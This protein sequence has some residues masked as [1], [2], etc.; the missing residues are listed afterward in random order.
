MQAISPP[1]QG[2]GRPQRNEGEIGK[3]R[4]EFGDAPAMSIGFKSFLSMIYAPDL[5]TCDYLLWL[6]S[7]RAN[8]RLYGKGQKNNQGFPRYG[9]AR[10]RMFAYTQQ[11]RANG[12]L[13]RLL[14]QR[15][16][17]ETAEG[18]QQ[19][20][21]H[22]H[23]RN[24]G[25]GKDLPAE[26]GEVNPKN[27]RDRSLDLPKMSGNHADHQLHQGT[28]NNTGHPRSPGHLVGKGKTTAENP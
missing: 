22:L 20:C 14:Q 10:H 13:L 28:P 24:Q 6:S 15:L 3:K 25:G 2:P 27:L 1:S 21:Y 17:G 18:R 4:P 26:L 5:E 19:R 9:M 12:A 7:V 11:G 16:T 23:P 8:G